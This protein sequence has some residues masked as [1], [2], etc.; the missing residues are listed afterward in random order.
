MR[1][2]SGIL[3]AAVL[4][5]ALVIAFGVS[6]QDARGATEVGIKEGEMYP[7]FVLPTLDGKQSRLSDY[8]GKKILLFHFASW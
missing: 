6:V 4:M 1:K 2:S 3:Q 8:R 7:D 5:A